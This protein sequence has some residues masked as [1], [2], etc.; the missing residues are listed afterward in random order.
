MCISLVYIVHLCYN[1]LCKNRKTKLQ[2][3]PF[4]AFV[5]K[6]NKNT[7]IT[8]VTSV[9]PSVCLSDRLLEATDTLQ[10]FL[11]PDNNRRGNV[12]TILHSGA[13]L[14]NNFCSGK[15]I[16]VTYSGGVSV[17]VGTHPEIRM[18]HIVICGLSGSTVFL[19]IIS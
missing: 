2:N 13:F 14:C 15:A 12:L 4:R 10:I 18:C 3:S 16:S 7:C 9:Y 17:V 19:H 8:S 11:R 1:A 6:S 5:T